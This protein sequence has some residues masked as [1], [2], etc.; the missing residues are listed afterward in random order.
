MRTATASQNA[1][2]A[3]RTSAA[4]EIVR[5]DFMGSVGEVTDC[6]CCGDHGKAKSDAGEE[7]DA[8]QGKQTAMGLWV[9]CGANWERVAVRFHGF[10]LLRFEGKRGGKQRGQRH[11][12]T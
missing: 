9:A 1:T 7:L 4:G 8:T 10:R 3:R 5:L 11:G 12:E 6:D 2:K